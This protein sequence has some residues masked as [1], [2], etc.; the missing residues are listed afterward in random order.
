MRMAGKIFMTGHFFPQFTCHQHIQTFFAFKH[1]KCFKLRALPIIGSCKNYESNQNCEYTKIQK[2]VDVQNIVINRRTN[3]AQV[4][5]QRSACTDSIW[6]C[7]LVNFGPWL[8]YNISNC[9]QKYSLDETKMK[10]R[11]KNNSKRMEIFCTHYACRKCIKSALFEWSWKRWC[12][13]S[14]ELT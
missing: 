2:V 10:M 6:A 13:V 3:S 12:H 8:E 5:L 11:E 7:P 9:S 4:F 1:S 14:H